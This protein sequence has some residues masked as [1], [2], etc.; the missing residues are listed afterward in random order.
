M[1]M[2]NWFMYTD[3]YYDVWSNPN[4]TQFLE[5]D[6]PNLRVKA[7]GNFAEGAEKPAYEAGNSFYDKYLKYAAPVFDTVTGFLDKLMAA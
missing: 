1:E 4:Y 2:Y 5:N 7:M 3:E 6:K